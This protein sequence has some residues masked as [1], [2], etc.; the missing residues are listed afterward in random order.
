MKKIFTFCLAALATSSIY[1]AGNITELAMPQRN[2]NRVLH[3]AADFTFSSASA[4]APVAVATRAGES[5]VGKSFISTF[6]DYDKQDNNDYFIVLDADTIE[7]NNDD[8]LVMGFAASCDVYGT[9]DAAKGTLT[10]PT[11]VEVGTY[12]VNDTTT[13]PIVLYNLD[14][15][16]G[17]Y[18]TAALVGTVADGKITFNGAPY[19]TITID[20]TRYVYE[21]LRGFEAVEANGSFAMT[22]G[23]SKYRVPV[24]INKTAEDAVSILGINALFGYISYCAVPAKFDAAAKTVTIES[25]TTIMNQISTN[26]LATKIPWMLFVRSSSGLTRDPQ[27]SVSVA[28]GVTTI[29][30][31]GNLFLGYAD[32]ESGSYRGYTMSGVKFVANYDLFTAD[33][34][35]PAD[36]TTATVGDLNYNLDNVAMTAEVSGVTGSVATIVVPN[37]I[38]V[39]GK[40]YAVTAVAEKAF[41]GNRVITT[42]TLPAS[43]KEVGTDAFRNV[44]KLTT[45]NIEDLV[46]W[47]KV[48]FTNGNANPIYNVYSSYTASR[49]GKVYFG[50]KELGADLVVPEGVD[51]LQRTFYGAKGIVNV[52][53]PSSLK[54]LGDQ[55]FANC[56]GIVELTIPEGVVSLGSALFSCKNITKLSLPST[57]E[58]VTNS[59]AFYGL[60]KLTELTSNAVVPPVCKS[61]TGSDMTTLFSSYADKTTLYVP[62]ASVEDYKASPVW[63]VFTTILPKDSAVETVEVE[64]NAPAEYYNLNGVKVDAENATPGIYVVRKGNK[65]SKVVVK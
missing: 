57:L 10:I 37:S 42:L 60:S 36:P 39:N 51:T 21:V 52:T 18:S 12:Q 1:A 65:V 15:A 9:Y 3:E 22:L 31:A 56:E 20:G 17:K 58:K 45:L 62:K 27:F 38:D 7:G 48:K 33:V 61:A 13:T 44:S 55:T 40:T 24:L 23:T 43:L 28:D 19:L 32:G 54:V 47:C 11:G 26:G 41:Y 14:E 50:G 63:G 64:D 53:L 49:W 2:A 4:Q 59:S 30:Y 29:A 16:A 25:T 34:V 35:A 46:A 8:V 6:A 5:I